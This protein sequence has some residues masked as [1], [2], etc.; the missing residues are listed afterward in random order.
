MCSSFPVLNGTLAELDFAYSMCKAVENSAAQTRLGTFWSGWCCWCD[1]V[2]PEPFHTGRDE[3]PSAGYDASIESQE[4]ENK[5]LQ[6]S[7]VTVE[8]MLRQFWLLCH[9][10]DALWGFTVKHDCSSV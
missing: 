3:P 6:T 7:I 1:D 2:E 5:D 9:M 8:R 10:F 4:Y